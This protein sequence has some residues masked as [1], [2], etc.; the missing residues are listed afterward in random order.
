MQ[1][2]LICVYN[3]TLIKRI[4]YR[5]GADKCGF[6]FFLEIKLCLQTQ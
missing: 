4:H 5:E 6:L 2:R 3:G 1:I